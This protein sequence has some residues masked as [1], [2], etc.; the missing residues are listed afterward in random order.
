MF[1]FSSYSIR[2]KEFQVLK[3]FIKPFLLHF[4]VIDFYLSLQVQEKKVIENV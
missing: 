2:Q 4:N 1:S 3:I